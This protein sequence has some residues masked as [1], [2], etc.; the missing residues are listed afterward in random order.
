MGGLQG[1]YYLFPRYRRKGI[2]EFVDTVISLEV[3]NEIAERDS[4]ADKYSDPR[5]SGSR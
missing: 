4:R 5:M 2:E 1:D 3:I